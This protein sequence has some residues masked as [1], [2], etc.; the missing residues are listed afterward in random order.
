MAEV[1]DAEISYRMT[2]IGE[3]T[4]NIQEDKYTSKEDEKKG[5]PYPSLV[6]TFDE[7]DMESELKLYTA[8][9]E[10]DTIELN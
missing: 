9:I 7:E 6:R 2:G 3:E 5:I 10:K 1:I 8:R 4:D